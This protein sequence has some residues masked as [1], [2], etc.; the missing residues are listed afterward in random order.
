MLRTSVHALF[1]RSGIPS[2][3][4]GRTVPCYDSTLYFD[5]LH[6]ADDKAAVEWMR[7]EALEGR[8][9]DETVFGRIVRKSAGR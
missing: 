6:I 9:R 7:R 1:D 2:D 5:D 3:K 8:D 4:W